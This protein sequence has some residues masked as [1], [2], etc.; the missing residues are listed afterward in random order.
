MVSTPFRE[1]FQVVSMLVD[2]VVSIAASADE[3]L[4][5]ATTLVLATG[6]SSAGDMTVFPPMLQDLRE[7]E[8]IQ[9]FNSHTART[10]FLHTRDKQIRKFNTLHNS[11]T[12]TY[13]R[14]KP[15]AA[16]NTV[17]NLS[18]HNLTQA[19][20]NVLSLGLNFATPPKKIPFTEIIQQTEPKLR[21]LNKAAA[22]NIRLLVTQ[23]LSTAKP[24]QPNLNKEERTAVKTLQ[25]NASIHIIQ[26][27]K[28][29]ATVVMDKTQYEQ[30]IQDILHTPTYTEL[31]R[32]LTPATERKLN[33]KLLELHRSNA[34]PQ[35][36]YFRLRASSS[37]CPILFG[38]PKIHKPSV[39][40]RP[41]ISTRGSPCYETAKHLS[42]I[43]Q[44]LVGNTEHH[45]NNSKHFIDILSQTTIN[46]TDTLVSFDV[47]SLFTSVPVNEACD[48]IKQ[49]LT[50][51]PSLSSRTQLTPQQIHDLLLTCLNST[52]FRWRD[53][54]YKQQQGA[55]MGSPLSPIIANIYM[56]H[57][58]SHALATAQHKPSLWLRYVDDIFTIWPHQADQLDDF[59][60]H[61]NEQHSNISFTVETEHNH[62]L[63]FLDVLVTKTNAGTFSHQV[64]RKPTHT[65]RY[66]HYRSFHH[67]AVRQSV[68]NALVRRAHQISDKEHL[69]QELEHITDTLTTINQ[70]PKHKINTQAPSH[71]NQAAKEQPITTVNLPY[72]G[73]TSHK[74]QR[75]FKSANIQVRH[76]SSNKLHNSLHSHKDKHPKHKQP[77]VYRIP[78][79][80][81]KV[82]IGETGRSLETRLKEHKTCYRRSEWEKS[83][84]VKHAQQSEH[85][86][87]WED[88]K[89]ITSIKNWN[90]RRIREA[91]EIHTHDT[92]TQD[93]GL[94]INIWLPL[95]NKPSN[96]SNDNNN[97]TLSP[98]HIPPST[99][100]S[101]ISSPTS[102]QQRPRRQPRLPPTTTPIAGSRRRPHR[103]KSSTPPAST[104]TTN[105][106]SNLRPRPTNSQVSSH[107]YT[108]PSTHSE[109]NRT[110]Q[111]PQH[112]TNS[113]RSARLRAR[114]NRPLPSRW[115][116]TWCGKASYDA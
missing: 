116:V 112:S 20:H 108:P 8:K 111:R 34:L 37:R 88:S 4:S 74:L 39:P 94:H 68:P 80:C 101:H 54:H 40:L 36:L 18:Q 29:N 100:S 90:T 56:E 45:I 75:I 64:Y 28:G 59:L 79:E 22:D 95:I 33:A 17:V 52:S 66:L 26:A 27:D 24:P 16:R 25:S 14:D 21:Y 43:L 19:E 96:T 69:R 42:D 13:T 83:A 55:A 48:I 77:G 41:I 2:D 6:T 99:S 30:K 53:T 115:H 11:H 85:R 61:L 7:R 65:H 47:E 89:L 81:G 97:N 31:K 1:V 51:D 110:H 67:P 93:T 109:N 3:S 114:L 107:R 98:Q 9:T 78:C 49:R 70:Y 57:F 106:D 92:V 46:P 71:P 63:P 44:P 23:A 35:Q 86:I 91:I 12:R 10:T 15:P 72:L 82:Y 87:N 58:E 60:S 50:D 84:I 113:R 76:T 38:Q 73:A 62:S 105:P 103:H 32:D 104:P 102:S 5:A